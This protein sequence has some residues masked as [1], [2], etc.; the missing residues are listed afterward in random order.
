MT[1]LRQFL[2]VSYLVLLYAF[3]VSAALRMFIN[4]PRAGG[5]AAMAAFWYCVYLDSVTVKK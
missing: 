2:N 4:D 5:Y 3:A 1:L